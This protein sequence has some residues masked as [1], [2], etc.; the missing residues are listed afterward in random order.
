M[1]WQPIEE[2]PKDGSVFLI[3]LPIAGNLREGDRRVYE[4]RWHEDQQQF[5]SVNGFLLFG[6]A[7]HWRPLPAPPEA[8]K[9][10]NERC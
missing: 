9:K 6:G 4:A 2:A 1:D 10:N 7:T 8:V 5:T 3:G